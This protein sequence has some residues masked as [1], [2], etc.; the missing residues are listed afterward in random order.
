MALQQIVKVTPMEWRGFASVQDMLRYHPKIADRVQVAGFSE[1]GDGGYGEWVFLLGDQSANVSAYPKLFYAPYSAPDGAAGAWS[2]NAGNSVRMASLGLAI[3]NDR[4]F[5][6]ALLYQFNAYYKGKKYCELP[7]ARILVSELVFNHDPKWKGTWGA[8]SDLASSRVFGSLDNGTV[9]MS[10][11]LDSANPTLTVRG[12]AASRLSGVYI[13]DVTF[14]SED[15]YNNRDLTINA[16]WN[17]RASRTAVQLEYIASAVKIESLSIFGYKQAL[18]LNE[19]WDG[20]IDKL[21]IGICS[22]ANGTVP[23]IWIG[24]EGADNSNNLT[25][26]AFRVEHCPFSLECGFIEHVRFNSGKIE[27]KRAVDATHP[28]VRIN[29]NATRYCFQEVLS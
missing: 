7:L 10:R 29:S 9:I 8:N 23:A 4:A 16:E 5:N 13:R 21:A 20:T 11:D 3:N 22:D 2:L 14:C 24:S 12:T 26:N 1:A 15:L 17:V 19:V 28:V 6:T 18:R 27:T 25:I